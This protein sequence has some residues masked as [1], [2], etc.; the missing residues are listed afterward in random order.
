MD[1]QNLKNRQTANMAVFRRF[2]CG[3]CSFLSVFQY[4]D[5]S[6]PQ[7]R[8]IWQIMDFENMKNRQTAKMAVF[9]RFLCGF[10]NDFLLFQ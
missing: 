7:N 6:N 8:L 2:L 3:F 1:F 9:W 5:D 10:F 4:F